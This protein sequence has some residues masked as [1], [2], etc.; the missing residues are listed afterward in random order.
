VR[1]NEIIPYLKKICPE[2]YEK[3]RKGIAKPEE[4]EELDRIVKRFI[5]LVKERER[6]D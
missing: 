6:G 3:V 5:A 1:K 4:I 2:L